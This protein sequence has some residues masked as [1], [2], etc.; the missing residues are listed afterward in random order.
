VNDPRILSRPIAISEIHGSIE[1]AV[2]AT[3]D[4]RAALAAAYDLI[5]VRRLSATVTVADAAAGFDVSGKLTADIVQ[6]C[7]VT[8]V[9]VEQRIAEPFALRF[10]PPGS[11][12]LAERAK[13]HAEIVVDAAAADPP[14]V[15]EGRSLDLGP[16][17]EEAF[18][19]AIDPY[20]RAPGATLPA[21]AA[22]GD[23]GADSPFAALAGLKPK[24][25]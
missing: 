13:P 18:V 11:P 5:E 15:L 23:G 14:E 17:V 21:E 12:E 7:V 24:A 16:V 20:P 8:L 9:P 1:V 3:A 2:E 10:V 6:E 4:E 22:T 25:R 19:L